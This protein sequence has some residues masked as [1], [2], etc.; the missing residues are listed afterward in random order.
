MGYHCK[1]LIRQRFNGLKTKQKTKNDRSNS[2]VF[3]IFLELFW[4]VLHISIFL[5][6]KENAKIRNL[7]NVFFSYITSNF[8]SER[9]YMQNRPQGQN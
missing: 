6:K 4:D 1:S 7:E 5:Q 2:I 3:A 9:K 8:N